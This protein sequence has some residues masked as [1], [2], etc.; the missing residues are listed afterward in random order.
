M[1]KRGAPLLHE[2]MKQTPALS[3]K[4]VNVDNKRHWS[5]MV[6]SCAL[7]VHLAHPMYRTEFSVYMEQHK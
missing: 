3:G 5:P 4:E 7:R 6:T 2:V 1:Q